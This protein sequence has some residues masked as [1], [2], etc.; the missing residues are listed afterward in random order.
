M[1]LERLQKLVLPVFVMLFVYYAHNPDSLGQKDINTVNSINESLPISNLQITDETH[2][3]VYGVHEWGYVVRSYA[4]KDLSLGAVESIFMGLTENFSH[5]LQEITSLVPADA[6][7]L[8]YELKDGHLTLNLSNEFLEYSPEQE[9][10]L[11]SALVWT[12]TELDE[13]ERVGFKIEGN[14]IANLS[15]T[16]PVG[17]GFTRSMGV[18]LE[19]D[20]NLSHLND[21]KP[22]TL[23]FLTDD[24][25]DASLI[26]VTR[27]IPAEENNI[28]YVVESLI[29]GPVDQEYITVF[30]NQTTLI[31]EPILE[32]GLLTLNFSS[33]LYYNQAQ[34]KVSSA[35]LKQLVMSLMDLEEVEQVSVIIEGNVK[36]FDET[37]NLNTIPTSHFAVDSFIEAQ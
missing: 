12:Y 10:N 3:V 29:A 20:M 33:D 32:N 24:Q 6:K 7:L 37:L 4:P 30:N 27:L 16:L 21:A 13:V 14:P 34:T 25:T 22:V 8:D 5:N 36:V 11:V 15:G 19:I 9:Q 1:K 17:R 26:P 35:M 31:D 18:N 23:Y 2:H 28:T